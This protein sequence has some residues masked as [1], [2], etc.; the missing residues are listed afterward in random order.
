MA[1]FESSLRTYLIAQAGVKAVFGSSNTRIYID[2]IDE[3][4]TP[5]YPFAII[6]TVAEPT[7]Y[8]HD[9][10]LA[11][12]ELM[13]IDTYSTSKTTASSGAAAIKA[14]LSGYSGSMGTIKVGSAFVIDTRGQWVPE[15][16]TFLRSMDVQFAQN[17]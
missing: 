8:A 12:R 17:S 1:D 14:A 7:D 3:S 6:R 11:D 9:G 5:T 16:R 10:A 2:K 15:N 13:Q 4:I